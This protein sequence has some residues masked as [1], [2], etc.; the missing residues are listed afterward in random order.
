[1]GGKGRKSSDKETGEENVAE[2]KEGVWGGMRGRTWLREGKEGR[3]WL[4]CV[5][6]TGRER[7]MI[8]RYGDDDDSIKNRKKWRQERDEERKMT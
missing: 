1:M 8:G 5:R 6:E 3:R 7:E 2:G 4:G